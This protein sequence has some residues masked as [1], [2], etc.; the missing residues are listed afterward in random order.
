MPRLDWQMWFAALG[1]DC[2]RSPWTRGLFRRLLEGEPSVLALLAGN[3]FPEAPPRYLR[4][5]V[6]DYAF[7]PRGSAAWW[8]R[9]PAGPFCPVLTL[10]EGGRLVALDA[11]RA[12]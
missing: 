11:R 4:A 5:W 7:A 2:T 8:E 10:D 6:H 9:R 1:G 12:P 3:P